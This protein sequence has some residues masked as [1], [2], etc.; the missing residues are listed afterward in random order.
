M[1][2]APY[3]SGRIIAYPYA[4]IFFRFQKAYI[5]IDLDYYAYFTTHILTPHTPSSPR[6]P[7]VMGV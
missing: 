4:L 1:V 2:G 6:P 3:L 7:S 5:F